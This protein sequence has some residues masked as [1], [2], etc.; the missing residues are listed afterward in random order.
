[1]KNKALI[2]IMI[3][4]FLLGLGGSLFVLFSGAKNTVNIISD[5]R[6]VES[7]DLSASPD[8]K[9]VVEYE[10]RTNTVEIKDGKIHVI[11]AECYD[12]TCMKMG[13]L[14][15]ASL[16]IVCLPNHLVIEYA[17][18]NNAPDAVTR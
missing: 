7:V 4:I 6:I 16:P 15:S 3:V 8:R 9:I 5:G 18:D 13:W 17:D 2:I 14:E 11:D 10:G 12:H 1:M